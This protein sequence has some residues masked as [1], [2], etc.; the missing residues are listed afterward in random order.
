LA[1]AAARSVT[2]E[3][4]STAS[5]EVTS[6]FFK[7]QEGVDVV[8]DA[9]VLAN[10]GSETQRK[11]DF[12]DRYRD[13]LN[14]SL[15]KLRESWEQNRWRV[16]SATPPLPTEMAVAQEQDA[17]SVAGTTA[18][19]ERAAQAGAESAP[20]YGVR[21]TA[22]L[23][24]PASPAIAAS[25]TVTSGAPVEDRAISTPSPPVVTDR[26]PT[27][28]PNDML[29]LNRQIE[30]GVWDYYAEHYAKIRGCELS[31]EGAV[32]E[33]K[34]PEYEIHKVFCENEAP[35]RVKCSAGTC[36]GLE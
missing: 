32:L 16:G 29:A 27:A 3:P 21:K 8:V 19:N 7:R 14:Q 36:R 35:F 15:G 25:N 28:R 23:P 4:V 24:P 10:K 2:E 12:T 22:P 5:V 20:A 9:S 1:A 18:T 31:G 13:D 34:L 26:A 33:Q 6:E 17:S 30:P 11:I